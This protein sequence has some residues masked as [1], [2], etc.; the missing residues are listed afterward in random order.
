MCGW[1]SRASNRASCANR[2]LI[3]SSD[4]STPGS[5]FT[6][7]A[8]PNGRCTAAYTTP[9]PPRPISPPMSYWGSA[10]TTFADTVT[11]HRR[12]TAG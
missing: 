2:A 12:A 1:S 10:A 11:R 5:R 8:R 4:A 7:T 6:A 9:I 3:R